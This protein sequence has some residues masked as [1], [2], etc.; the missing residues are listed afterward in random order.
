MERRTHL[1]IGLEGP[2]GSGKTSAGN[3]LAEKLGAVVYKTP[4]DF[5]QTN[6][7][8]V[9]AVGG[10]VRFSYYLACC[11]WAAHQI[12]ELLKHSDVIV[13]RYIFSALAYHQAMGV[14]LSYINFS[15]IPIIM[16]N[17]YFYIYASPEVCAERMH[18]RGNMSAS[19][20]HIES[21][22]S[23]QKRIHRAY[24]K[25]PVISIDSSAMSQEEVCDTM[26]HFI[27][28]V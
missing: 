6:R 12:Q 11:F 21:D 14:D 25:L 10:Q 9:D 4:S 1:L 27:R 24:S 15:R 13:D 2:D 20:R 19:D 22:V 18:R 3:R 5:Y 16:P 26:V 23:L 17:F 8:E 28:G 7:S